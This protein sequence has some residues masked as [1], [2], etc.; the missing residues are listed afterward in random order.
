MLLVYYSYVLVGYSCVLVC[1]FHQYSYVLLCYLCQGTRVVFWSLSFS[2]YRRICFLLQTRHADNEFDRFPSV[3][4]NLSRMMPKIRYNADFHGFSI[5]ASLHYYLCWLLYSRYFNLVPDC[6]CWPCKRSATAEFEIDNIFKLIARVLYFI[7]TEIVICALHNGPPYH[8]TME[9]AG[10]SHLH[11][12]PPTE[13]SFENF[14]SNMTCMALISY[15]CKLKIHVFF[16]DKK[17]V[18]QIF[19][20]F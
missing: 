10:K 3:T 14:C 9:I 1:Y 19:R 16:F 13:M 8:S 6:W 7:C 4:C 15:V 11:F 12:L 20:L 18:T 17:S 5:S 2:R